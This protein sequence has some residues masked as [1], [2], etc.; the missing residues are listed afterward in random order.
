MKKSLKTALSVTALLGTLSFSFAAPNKIEQLFSFEMIGADIAYFESLAGIA[1]K[2][3]T[4]FQTKH[5]MVDGCEVTM[6]YRD[7]SVDTLSVELD[8]ECQFTLR[9]VIPYKKSIHTNQLRFG[10]ISPASYYAD[11]LSSCGNAYDPLVHE[12]HLGSRGEQFREVLLSSVNY[13]YDAKRTWVDKMEKIEGM[14]WII[15]N[16]H[17]C[18][19]SKYGNEAEKAL[20]GT[21]VTRITIGYE[22]EKK[23]QLQFG[24]DEPSY[25]VEAA[26]DNAPVGLQAVPFQ[27][28]YQKDDYR[29]LV[30]SQVLS[31][32]L[33][34]VFNEMYDQYQFWF[35]LDPISRALL[36]FEH[37][38]H[39][40][41]EGF[42][43][44]P[45]D[46]IPRAM[47]YLNIT[48]NIGD[49]AFI[50]RNCSITGPAK[51]H[52]VGAHIYWPYASEPYLK[53]NSLQR[54]EAGPYTMSCERF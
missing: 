1:R 29:Y 7:Q 14:E 19:P 51:L 34:Y 41:I 18:D 12:L 5:Y 22:L 13:D 25:E 36:N 15:N 21:P 48:T 46:E 4:H 26:A 44:I 30:G 37:D 42:S 28:A 33:S 3:D 53:L 31:G 54:I 10:N 45:K 17:N 8:E 9:D 52:I 16:R 6:G 35:H 2:T 39:F 43:D 50:E 11:C 23:A 27:V 47:E 20:K 38:T 49:P 24:C 32:E 40:E